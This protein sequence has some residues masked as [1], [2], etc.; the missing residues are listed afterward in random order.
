MTTIT[1]SSN[2]AVIKAGTQPAAGVMTIVTFSSRLDM[3]WMLS[4][5][6]NPVMTTATGTRYVAVIEAGIA[7]GVG[8]VTGIAL[9][10]R[11]NMCR[12]FTGCCNA[13]MAGTTGTNNS[14]MVHAANT[15]E[16]DGVMAVFAGCCG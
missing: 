16:S 3:C 10:S 15:I 7:P 14:I 5:C 4:C 6:C 11:Y 9:F 12:V 2:V 8:V 13:V 1:G